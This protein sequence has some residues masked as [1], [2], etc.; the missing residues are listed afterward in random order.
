MSELKLK[1]SEEFGEE[2]NR[3]KEKEERETRKWIET[4]GIM[5]LSDLTPHGA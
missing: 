4:G 1:I 5:C 3:G 2:F